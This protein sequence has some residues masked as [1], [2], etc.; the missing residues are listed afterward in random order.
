MN[1]KIYALFIFSV[2]STA[3]FSQTADSTA[4]Q[5]IDTIA[6]QKAEGKKAVQDPWGST[7]LIDAQTS[8]I[9]SKGSVEL[10][11]QHRFSNLSNNIHDLFGLYGASNIRM[12]LSYS[13]IDRLM[14]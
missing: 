3:L 6:Q 7:M 13:I 12:S 8:L 1:K 10:V 5:P 9:P 4:S 11:I 14:I 2:L